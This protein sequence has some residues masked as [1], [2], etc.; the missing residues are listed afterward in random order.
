[1]LS[2]AA[3]GADIR[4]PGDYD[5]DDARRAWNLAVDQRPDAVAFP[6]SAAEVAAVVVAAREDGLRVAPQATGHSAAPLGPL[7]GTVLLRTD[8]LGGIAI[9]P[10]ARV[11]RVG[12]GV[13]AAD[14][15]RAAAGHGLMPLAGSS[16]DVGIVGYTLGGGL[17]WSAR[18]HGLACNSVGAIEL[19]AADG[20]ELRADA[21][22]ERDL[23]WA[24]RGGGGSFGVV[25]ALELALVPVPSLCAGVLSYPAERAIEVL[26]CWCD[27]V[28]AAPDELTST[29]RILQ[30][31]PVP[32]L[33]AHLRGRSLVH[34]EV[35]FL[36][37][38][39][40]AAALLAPL[41]ALGPETDSVTTMSPA[42]LAR[43]REDPPQPVPAICDSLLLRELP[44]AAIDA[45]VS[46]TGPGSR[47]PLVGVELRHLGGALASAPEGAGAL[48]SLD[49]EFALFA[50]GTATAPARV[51]RVEAQL[52][53]LRE[54]LAPWEAPRAFLNFVERPTDPRAFFKA[55]PYRLLR[56]IKGQVD[57]NDVIR[58]NHAI[59]PA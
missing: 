8:R 58:A 23:F 52:V 35:V 42:G 33:P 57:P 55:G 54:A 12:A 27:L 30:Y 15:L 59:P 46:A 6:E 45:F 50:M 28:R 11:A 38:H 26:H 40:D 43:L 14:L 25:T 29:A 13:R 21:R 5:W 53:R 41:L 2:S 47:S 20:R 37:G 49:A 22:T 1:V 4:R 36:G 16:L 19:V 17:G 3:T 56:Q 32:M 34:V 31:P 48:G 51:A 18:R 7:D 9:D 10:A 24:L 44:A 39:D